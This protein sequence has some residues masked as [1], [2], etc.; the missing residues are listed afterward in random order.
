MADS[1]MRRRGTGMGAEGIM[2]AVDNAQTG[3]ESRFDGATTSQT[4]VGMRRAASTPY[5]PAKTV[6]PSAAFGMAKDAV[7]RLKRRVMGS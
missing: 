4:G 7:L 6:T 5:V 3:K 2:A 1:G